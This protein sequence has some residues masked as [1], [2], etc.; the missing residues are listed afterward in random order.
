MR[1]PPLPPYERVLWQGYPSWA[2]HAILFLF[3]GVAAL[4]V[5]LAFRS[6]EWLTAGLYLAAIGIFFG[7]AASFRYA[8]LYQITSQRIRVVSGLG[9]RQIRELPLD[10]IESVTVRRELVNG[11]FNLGTLV[12]TPRTDGTGTEE[13]LILKGIPDPDRVKQQIERAAGIRT[14]ASPHTVATHP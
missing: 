13:P 12:I 11:W 2:D 3:M 6:G 4:R 8:S 5:A 9:S 10:R 7:I 14:P 1:I